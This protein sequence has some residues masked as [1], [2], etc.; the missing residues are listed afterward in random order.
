VL[1]VLVGFADKLRLFNVL[2]ED[3]RQ[4]ADLPVKG[5]RECRFSHGG[6]YFAAVSGPH[7]HVFD[8]YTTEQRC[9]LKGHSGMV[10]AISWR[11][12]DLGMAS[13]GVDG[14]VYEWAWSNDSASAVMDRVG[15]SD[16]V[17][18]SS[19]YET[20]VCGPRGKLG[21]TMIAAGRDGIIREVEMGNVTTE[22]VTDLGR[23]TQLATSRSDRVLMV[24]THSGALRAYETPLDASHDPVE[25]AGIHSS[26]VTRLLL[27]QDEAFAFSASEDGQLFMFEM[28]GEGAAQRE[29]ARRKEEESGGVETDTVLVSKGELLE[30][31]ANAEEL[32][33]R[34]KEQQM[35]SEYQS[36]LRE[37][38]FQDTLRKAKEEAHVKMVEGQEA[39]EEMRHQ[40]DVTSRDGAE[41]L[42]SIEVRALTRPFGPP[43]RVM[44]EHGAEG[45]TPVAWCGGVVCAVGAHEGG[46][47]AGARV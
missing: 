40:K 32:E 45:R 5:C 39:L 29:R 41:A 14:A 20:V 1:Q 6:Q 26:A 7:I 30:R 13:A 33:Q 34:V 2:M 3:V 8:T 35:Q 11:D 43:P 42:A 10:R 44:Q 9:S 23:V 24:G 16:H 36:H 19:Q 21:T 18:K 46:R 47:G 25:M 28:L 37:Q 31:I 27:S 17:F 38:Y 12:G 15:S 4:T 22:I